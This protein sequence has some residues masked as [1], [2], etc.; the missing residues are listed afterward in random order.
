METMIGLVI[1]LALAIALGI[2]LS[3][4]MTIKMMYS[5]KGRSMMRDVLTSYTGM[6][7]D[8]A[9]DAAKKAEKSFNGDE[10]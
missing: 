5:S 3:Y 9:L 1:S 8:I 6:T 4:Y 10:D 2:C 7:M